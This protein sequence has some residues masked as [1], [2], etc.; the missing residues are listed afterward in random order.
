MRYRILTGFIEMISRTNV[1][2]WLRKVISV[3][4]LYVFPDAFFT[5]CRMIID[6]LLVVAT[7]ASKVITTQKDSIRRRHCTFDTLWMI[8][9]HLCRNS[10]KISTRW[11][12]TCSCKETTFHD[13]STRRN[14]HG[15]AIAKAIIRGT[16]IAL[17]PCIKPRPVP[18]IGIHST[19]FIHGIN[20]VILL[21]TVHDSFSNSTGHDRIISEKTILT[22]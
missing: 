15:R 16:I 20:K 2:E 6:W 13:P 3:L 8:M 9:S 21:T 1:I 22:K 7:V 18:S 19:I 4:F 5:L 10:R 17:N 14:T 11:P 12:S